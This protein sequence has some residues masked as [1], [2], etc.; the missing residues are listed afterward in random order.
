MKTKSFIVIFFKGNTIIQI[1]TNYVL[2]FVSIFTYSQSLN[3]EIGQSTAA[4]SHKNQVPK[5][6]FFPTSGQVFRVAYAQTFWGDHELNIGASIEQAN[7]LGSVIDTEIVYDTQFL[8]IF[9]KFDMNIINIFNRK[10]C[11]SCTDI[12]FFATLGGQLSTLVG[13]SQKINE[14]TYSLKGIEDFKGLWVAPLVGIKVKFDAADF[15]SLY[16]LYEFMPMINVTD[17]Q[18]KF[19]INQ[20]IMALG[21]RLWL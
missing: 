18:E 16:G 11:S 17:N 3:M 8:G 19:R 6:N 5:V 10:H 15:M 21:I 14:V 2:F 7:S 9:G 4:Y 12:Q 13:G 1:L 20:R